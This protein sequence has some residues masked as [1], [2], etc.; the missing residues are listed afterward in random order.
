MI[1]GMA[2]VRSN[3]RNFARWVKHELLLVEDYHLAAKRAA[4]GA[5]YDDLVEESPVSN[6]ATRP[7]GG[8]GQFRASWQ[9]S[10]DAPDFTD[11]V[12]EPKPFHPAPGA[13]RIGPVVAAMKSG[14]RAFVV[15]VRPYANRL[16]Y[17]W[18]R[19]A[20]SGWVH[21]AFARAAERYQSE[22]EQRKRSFRTREAR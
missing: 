21:A 4:F 2:K 15:N 6:P 19:Q 14:Q 7:E 16:A 3:I 10:L 20:P 18:S 5:M 13:E 12:P 1:P 9:P 17:G 11:P 8:H 22:L